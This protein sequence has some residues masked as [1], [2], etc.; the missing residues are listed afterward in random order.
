MR[1]ERETVTWEH[2]CGVQGLVYRWNAV[3]GQTLPHTFGQVHQ[4]TVVLLSPW[5]DQE[6]SK[7]ISVR[8][9]WISF[10][11]LPCRKDN[12]MTARISMLLE[13]HA[14]LTWFQACFLPGWTKDLSAPQYYHNELSTHQMVSAL[15]KF[16]SVLSQW[17]VHTP[18][19]Q[20]LGQVHQCIVTMNCPHTRW[21]VS[22]PS[23]PVYCHNELSTHPDGHCPC[24]SQQ[25][26]SCRHLSTST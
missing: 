2:I 4:C 16:T 7:L 25:T 14:S 21:S 5:P 22:W 17:I 6:G 1:G 19:G 20:C 3:S 11:S 12:L 26:G 15:S 23:S 24:H 8:T 13:S 10:S 9:V 18:D